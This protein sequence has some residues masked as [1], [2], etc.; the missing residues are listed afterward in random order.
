MQKWFD[1]IYLFVPVDAFSIILEQ[2]LE[3]VVRNILVIDHGL[4]TN[5]NPKNT[6]A[7]VADWSFLIA[8]LLLLTI[9]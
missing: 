2:E 6:S 4:K 7:G 1:Y 9:T 5:L 8:I 3:E